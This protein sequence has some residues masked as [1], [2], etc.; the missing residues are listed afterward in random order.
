MT[1]RRDFL[2]QS[3][4]GTGLV[5]MA[6]SLPVWAANEVVKTTGLSKDITL[7]SPDENGAMLPEGFTSR[8]IARTGQ[9]ASKNSAYKWHRA[10]DGGAVFSVIDENHPKDKPCGWVYVSNAETPDNGGAGALMF[11]PETGDI[12]DSYSILEG[13]QWNCAGG[14]T[15]WNTWLSCEEHPFG[16]VWECD[17]FGNEAPRVLPELGT[18]KHEAA[19]IDP[20]TNIVYMTEDQP[21]GLFYRF[22]PDVPNIGAGNSNR[23][24]YS[25]GKLQALSSPGGEWAWVNIPKPHLGE[26]EPTRY[27]IENPVIFN[28]G[29]GCVYHDSHIFFTSKGD[30]KVWYYDI[31]L[32]LIDKIYHFGASKTPILSGVDNIAVNPNGDLSVAEDGG[33][34]ELVGLTK[35][36]YAYPMLRLVGHT[37]SEIAGP[38]F[39]PDGTRLYFSSQRGTGGTHKDGITF[40]ITGKF[41]DI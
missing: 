23:A 5:T 12:I 40:E 28:G 41:R 15:P 16:Q 1:S 39:S 32:G 25:S 8:I 35:E 34:L 17:P 38:A 26:Y 9:K 27:Q 13:T 4:I 10:P 7:L 19:A 2:R 21:D 24:D 14:A 6:S 37:E 30:N 29:E 22:V 31:D 18:F 36:G 3:V 20:K 33:N 11:H